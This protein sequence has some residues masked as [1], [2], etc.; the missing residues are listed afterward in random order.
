MSTV[1]GLQVPVIPLVDVVGNEGT[2]LPAQT[3]SELPKLNVGAIFGLTV[4]VSV[5]LVAHW[6]PAEVKVYVPEF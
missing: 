1:A 4:T 2:L 5:V 6:P 3:V